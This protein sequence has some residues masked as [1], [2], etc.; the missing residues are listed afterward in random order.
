VG[1]QPVVR[2]HVA[3]NHLTGRA[4]SQLAA[5][6]ETHGMEFGQDRGDHF[7]WQVE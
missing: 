4:V 5:V 7:Q 2:G 6:H 1:G 3:E